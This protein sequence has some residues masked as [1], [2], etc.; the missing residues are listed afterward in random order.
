M[1]SFTVTERVVIIGI[2]YY[3]IVQYNY[4]ILNLNLRYFK[5]IKEAPDI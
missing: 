5:A 1:C 2:N 4:T 3:T